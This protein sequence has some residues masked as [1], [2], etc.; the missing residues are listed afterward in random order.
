MLTVRCAQTSATSDRARSIISR[1]NGKKILI[2]G[3]H[4]RPKIIAGISDLFEGIYDLHTAKIP[5]K[6][7]KDGKT[8]RIV[9]CHYPLLVWDRAHYGAWMLHGHCH[10]SLIEETPTRRMDVGVDCWDYSPV[11]YET[12]KTV[13]KTRTY[14]SYDHH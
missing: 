8:Q 11:S 13:M 2:K 6:E 10:G 12:I 9:M 1:L 5:D 4:D 7:A 14:K 3:N